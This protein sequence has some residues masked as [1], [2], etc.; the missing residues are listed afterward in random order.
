MVSTE[1]TDLAAFEDATRLSPADLVTALRVAL[2]VRLV[3]VI[4]GVKE[5][6]AVHQWADGIREM[7]DPEV[8]DRLR[9]AYRVVRT[10]EVHDSPQTVQ[11]WMQG[12]NPILGEQSPARLLRDGDLEQDGPR[13][14]DAARAFASIA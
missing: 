7:R 1:H 6:R 3:A 4:A 9:V 12:L 13:V 10:L 14:L 2:G 11:A 5:T 8:L